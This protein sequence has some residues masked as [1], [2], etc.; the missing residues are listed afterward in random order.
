M[1]ELIAKAAEAMG[2]PGAMVR[3]SAEARAKAEGMSVEEVLAEWAGVEVPSGKA[4]EDEADAPE[5]EAVERDDASDSADEAPPEKPPA[6]GVDKYVEIAAEMMKMP[7]SMIRRSAEARARTEG[8]SYEEV[9]ADW[10]EV[11]V[12]DVRAAAEEAEKEAT[13]APAPT[14]DDAASGQTQ[15]PD[16]DRAQQEESGD[17]VAEGDAPDEDDEAA[18]A[19]EE[20]PAVEVIGGDDE[21]SEPEPSEDEEPAMAAVGVGLPTWLLALFIIVPAFAIGYASFFPNGPNCGDA[22][23]LAVD[24][25]TGI[26]VNCD[27]TAYGEIGVDFFAM[28]ADVY[29]VCA[30]C[31]GQGGDGGAGPA[32]IGGALLA[33]FPEGQCDLHTEW[34]RLGTQGWPEPTYGANEKPVGGFGAPMPGF[35]SLSDE[36]LAAVALYERVQF[37]GE[38]LEAALVDCGLVDG[39]NGDDPGNGPD[40]DGDEAGDGDA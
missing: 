13:D 6:T 4:E 11:D 38:A 30:G 35:G 15:E 23:R 34:I 2:M 22:G 27:G 21:P 18:A 5:G 17:D 24:P 7:A 29:A 36:E 32:F 20:G 14:S 31:H 16:D 40:D 39:D 10:A 37:G 3:R 1:D 28:G 26:A 19:E 9:L 33:T 8:R 25:V 12:A